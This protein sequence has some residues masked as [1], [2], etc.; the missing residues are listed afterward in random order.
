MFLQELVAAWQDGLIV[1]MAHGPVLQ[2]FAGTLPSS[3]EMI[4]LLLWQHVQRP[5]G[6]RSFQTPLLV[7]AVAIRQTP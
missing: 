7:T 4:T 3:R 1:F 5:R 6:N 2:C